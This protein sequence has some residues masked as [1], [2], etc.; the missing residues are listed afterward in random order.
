ME[1]PSREGLLVV[2]R[3][4]DLTVVPPTEAHMAEQ[5]FAELMEGQPS[6]LAVFTAPITALV[7][8]RQVSRLGRLHRPYWSG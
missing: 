6:L 4:V 7:P 8:W 5:P 1:A 3:L 2:L